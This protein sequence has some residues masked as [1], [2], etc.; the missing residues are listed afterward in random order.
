M[1]NETT[2]KDKA[3]QAPAPI[4]QKPDANPV[5]EAKESVEQNPAQ[6]A[7]PADEKTGTAKEPEKESEQVSAEQATDDAVTSEKPK[8]DE[9]I[10]RPVGDIILTV[11]VKR[12]LFFGV[13]GKEI[14]VLQN[15][16]LVDRI[17]TDSRGQALFKL[18]TGDYT[19]VKG[20]KKVPIT[21]QKHSTLRM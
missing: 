19:V 4:E 7:N 8:P 6:G 2:E 1:A 11:K 17:T 9:H 20:D 15:D 5:P 13:A 3:A 14:Q 10:Q 18:P 16:K 12:M 21:L